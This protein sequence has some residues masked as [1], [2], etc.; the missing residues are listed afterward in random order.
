MGFYLQTGSDPPF[1]VRISASEWAEK[2]VRDKDTRHGYCQNDQSVILHF[3]V[4]L[5][6][7]L[8]F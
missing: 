4:E 6:K 5:F 7:E 8:I 3:Q 1:T 2:T